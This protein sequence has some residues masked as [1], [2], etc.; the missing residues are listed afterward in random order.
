MA[1]HGHSFGRKENISC[2]IS[3]FENYVVR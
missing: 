2:V 1:V 3:F